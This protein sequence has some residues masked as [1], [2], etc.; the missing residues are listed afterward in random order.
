MCLEE[1]C[2]TEAWSR[3]YCLKH[4]QSLRRKGEFGSTAKDVNKRDYRQDMRICIICEEEFF[5]RIDAK[6]CGPACRQRLHRLSDEPIMCESQDEAI[7]CEEAIKC[8]SPGHVYAIGADT[9][10]VKL[11][12]SIHPEKRV[13]EIQHMSPIA[14]RLLATLWV[15][16]MREAERLLHEKYAHRRMWGEWFDITHSEAIEGLL[17]LCVN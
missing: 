2:E 10:A 13:K 9:G 5:G 16:D 6:T 8:E 11:G 14:L 7:I 3:G 12:F 4:Y 17:L 15:P 1:N